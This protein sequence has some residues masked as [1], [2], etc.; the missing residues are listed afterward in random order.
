MW[1]SSGSVDVGFSHT[2]GEHKGVVAGSS[3]IRLSVQR[4]VFGIRNFGP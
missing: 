1:W 2:T 3:I 4:V